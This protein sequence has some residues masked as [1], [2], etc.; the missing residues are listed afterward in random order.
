M[1]FSLCPIYGRIDANGYNIVD[2]RRAAPNWVKR[3]SPS[4]NKQ[5]TIQVVVES[6]FKHTAVFTIVSIFVDRLK[7]VAVVGKIVVL[8]VGR[9]YSE[10]RTPECV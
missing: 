6:V 1:I 4:L 10:D 9:G 3:P 2:F 7:S 8:E 5:R